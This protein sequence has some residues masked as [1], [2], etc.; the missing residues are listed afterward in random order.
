[1]SIS[2]LFDE[3]LIVHL[4]LNY[5]L[6]LSPRLAVNFYSSRRDAT[7][8]AMFR[9]DIHLL[10]LRYIFEKFLYHYTIIVAHITDISTQ[11]RDLQE[12]VGT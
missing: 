1:V 5:P 4:S 7:F 3:A 12:R 11:P 2:P 9:G 8:E 6:H 10:C